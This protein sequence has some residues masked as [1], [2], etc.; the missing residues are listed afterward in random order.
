[1][2]KTFIYVKH[3]VTKYE[4]TNALV[5]GTDDL[6]SVYV[7]SKTLIAGMWYSVNRLL[8]MHD[9]TAKRNRKGNLF[10]GRKQQSVQCIITK[11]T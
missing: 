8:N 6:D 4:V 1:M 5:N 11:T 3:L 7:Q 9:M 2:V 10:I